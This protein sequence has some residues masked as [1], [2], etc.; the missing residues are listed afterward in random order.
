MKIVG[1]NKNA[2]AT[3]ATGMRAEAERDIDVVYSND[4]GRQEMRR[5]VRASTTS[6]R[7]TEAILFDL[8]VF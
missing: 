8:F 1:T 5:A 4:S 3:E 2:M 7:V 6:K